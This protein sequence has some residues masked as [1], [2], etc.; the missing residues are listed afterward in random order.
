MS[1]GLYMDVN[2]RSAITRQ[3][4]ARGADVLTSQEDGTRESSDSALLDR[5]TFLNRVMFTCDADLIGEATMRQR[6][7]GTFAGVIYTPQRQVTIG[8]CVA[9][10]ELIAKVSERVEW[11]NRI[12]FLP[13]R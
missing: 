1:I 4:R 6:S 11:V 13:M 7:G 2:V 3:L 12:A 5:A 8:Q 10:L 9:D